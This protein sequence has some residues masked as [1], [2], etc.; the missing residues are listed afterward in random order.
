M[1]I[2]GVT[3]T[4]RT[5][6]SL[7]IAALALTAATLGAV[8]GSGAAPPIAQPSPAAS[9]Q[10]PRAVYTACDRA[11]PDCNPPPDHAPEP[12]DP[13]V[14]SI[15]GRDPFVKTLIGDGQLWKDYWLN[16]SATSGMFGVDILF[17]KPVSFTGTVPA[18]S[19]PCKGH[20]GADERIPPDDP[21]RQETPVDSTTYL[22]FRDQR[23][24]Q[25]FV[26]VSRDRVVDVFLPYSLDQTIDDFIAYLT[27]NRPTTPT[28]S[29]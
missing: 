12:L 18:R 26:D 16:V 29:P 27:R 4:E 19:Q 1:R 23:W 20:F 6:L 2:R 21:C 3:V 25:V 28:P 8:C 11:D 14:L 22:D 9:A 7:A 10:T 5:R 15:L 24:V 17:A 13:A